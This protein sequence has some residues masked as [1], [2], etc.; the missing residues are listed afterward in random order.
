MK[1]LTLQKNIL[2]IIISLSVLAFPSFA[3]AQLAV[4]FDPDPLFNEG[5]ALP[6]D[7]FN[8]TVTVTNNSGVPQTIITEAIN[9]LD[10]DGLSDQMTLT[11][12]D[13][14]VGT[15]FDAGDGTFLDFLTG[16]IFTLTNPLGDGET[17]EYTFDVSFLEG[18]GN[19]F[20]ESTFGFDLCVGFLDELNGMDCGN[21][22]VSSEGSTGED[23]GISEVLVAASGGGGGG[24]I[25]YTTSLAISD[26][27]VEELDIDVQ[28]ALIEWNTNL[29]ATSQVVYGPASGGPYSISLI[30]QNFGYP[31][32]T[33]E[34]TDKTV[35]HGILLEG[36]IPGEAYN[37]RV[38]S[39][40]S[41]PTISFEHTFTFEEPTPPLPVET[42]VEVWSGA[43]S[44][45][46]SEESSS[47][48]QGGSGTAIVVEEKSGG[49]VEGVSLEESTDSDGFTENQP[50]VISIRGEES[51]EGSIEGGSDDNSTQFAGS[52]F[53]LPFELFPS[54]NFIGCASFFLLILI[55]IYLVWLLWVFKNKR[56]YS[57]EQQTHYRHIYFST[58]LFVT[59]VIAYTFNA[60]CVTLPLLI[61]FVLSLIWAFWDARKAE[62]R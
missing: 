36:L 8:G 61:T 12:T 42:P 21:T 62:K 32:A 2:W 33:P 17:I 31:F 27:H 40:S 39:R 26:E 48:G 5:N 14:S 50:T 38:V 23:G 3:F 34:S 29:Y 59:M 56:K 55:I 54:G 25:I 43:G 28:T 24:G 51:V 7:G 35:N 46:I 9:L 30:L 1:L 58:A 20:Q 11:V 45:G 47:F 19:A 6:G 4:I 44:S 18:S 60:T 22:V 57:K 41:P 49:E 37:Y 52:V 13:D 16:G 10:P 53:G 15:F